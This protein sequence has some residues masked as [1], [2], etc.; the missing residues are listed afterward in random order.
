MMIRRML[1]LHHWLEKSESKLPEN[2]TKQKNNCKRWEG[3]IISDPR[4]VQAFD[5]LIKL[6][7]TFGG[8]TYRARLDPG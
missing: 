3:E 7:N 1:F 8:P 5:Q 2:K 4:W 6:L